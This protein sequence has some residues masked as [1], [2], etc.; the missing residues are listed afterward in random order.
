M[1]EGEFNVPENWDDKTVTALSFPAGA[2]KPEASF[3]VT[4]DV[5][6]AP[7]ASLASYVDKQLVDLAKTC[8]RFELV[9]RDRLEI[10]GAPAEQ[11]RFTWRSPDGTGVEQQQTSFLLPAKGAL[12]FTATAQHSKF[13]EFAPLFSGLVA[14]FRFRKES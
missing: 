14:G 12:T 11:L 7:G 2:K 1:N 3:A 13:S 10:D 5:N 4:R 9:S 6:V 8:P